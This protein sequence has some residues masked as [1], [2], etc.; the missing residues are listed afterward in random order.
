MTLTKKQ[1]DLIIAHTKP[2]LKGTQVSLA[3][4]LGYFMK[5]GANWSYHV[6]WTYDGDLVCTV[7]GEVK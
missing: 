5:S 7:Y 1:V 2:E 6:G 3:Q 4:S